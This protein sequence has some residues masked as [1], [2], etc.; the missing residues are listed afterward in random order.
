MPSTHAHNIRD[1]SCAGRPRHRQ[2]D[3]ELGPVGLV[4]AVALDHF[5]VR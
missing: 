2:R 4:A 3:A 1:I 5:E